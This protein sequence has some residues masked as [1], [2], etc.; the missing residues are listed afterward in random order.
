MAAKSKVEVKGFEA[1]HYDTLLNVVSLGWYARFIK[2]AIAD[3]DIHPGERILDLGSGTGR[4]DELMAHYLQGRGVVLGLDIGEEMLEQAYE[5][6]AEN[7]L[8][9]FE[10][11]RIDEPLPYREEFDRVFIC[12]VLH[13]FEHPVRRQIVQNASRALKPGGVFNI[14][15]YAEF[16]LEETNW[17]FRLFFTK[18][19]CELAAEFIQHDWKQEL[20]EFGFVRFQEKF[21]LG[22]KIRL[23]S[24]WKKADDQTQEEKQ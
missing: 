8:L 15:D 22:N 3:L 2:Q 18:G 19:E 21:Y 6:A 23:L 10:K 13:G 11:R 4:N 12:F 1:R 14:I 17:P 24:A 16:D 9:K 20:R 7:P 5:R